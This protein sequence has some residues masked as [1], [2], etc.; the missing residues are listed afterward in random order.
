MLYD[1][2]PMAGY[3]CLR[4]ATRVIVVLKVWGVTVGLGVGAKEGKKDAKKAIIVSR[5]VALWVES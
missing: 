4:S 5:V 2:E 3:C 1:R